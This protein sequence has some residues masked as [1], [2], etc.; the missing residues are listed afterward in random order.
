MD[1]KWI[2]KK[3]VFM[4]IWVKNK[5]DTLFLIKKV[6]DSLDKS[7]E[8][9]RLINIIYIILEKEEVLPNISFFY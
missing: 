6:L 1:D 7:R 8:I 2:G 5:V 3:I 4:L 9:L